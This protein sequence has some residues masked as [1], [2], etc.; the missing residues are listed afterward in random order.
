MQ[1]I[2]SLG[3]NVGSP[4][5]I[6]SVPLQGLQFTFPIS[7]ITTIQLTNISAERIDQF[8]I[9]S[10]D[11]ILMHTRRKQPNLIENLVNPSLMKILQVTTHKTAPVQESKS[12]IMF[13]KVNLEQRK[14]HFK[15]MNFLEN[16]L[17]GRWEF[18]QIW[19]LLFW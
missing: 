15:T 8:F 4:L 14:T 10:N 16:S 7:T 5:N 3:Q 6:P 13:K 17:Q 11:L 18:R 1:P 19:Q 12:L 9:E 2:S